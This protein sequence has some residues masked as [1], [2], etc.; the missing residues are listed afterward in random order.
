MREHAPVGLALALGIV[1]CSGTDA[2]AACNL[3]DGGCRGYGNYAPRAYGYAPPVAY[4][5]APRLYYAPPPAYFAAPPAYY[6][7]PPAAYYGP[8]VY[9]GYGYNP[10]PRTLRRRFSPL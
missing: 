8:P 9:A 3:R 7:A 5:Q 6:Y 4:Y 10:W 1:A 2:S